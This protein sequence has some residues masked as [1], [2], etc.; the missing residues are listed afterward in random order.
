MEAEAR[1][2]LEREGAALADIRIERSMDIHYY[3]QVREQNADVPDGPV[4]AETLAVTVDRFHDKHRRVIG[5]SEPGYPTVIVRLHLAG[6]AK[7]V[8]PPPREIS[9]GSG[10]L[11]AALKGRRAAYFAEAGGLTEVPVYDGE[12]FGAGDVIGGPCI[13]EE[14]MTTLVLPPAEIVTVDSDGSYTTISSLA[15]DWMTWQTGR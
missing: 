9:R 11:A 7:I 13:I 1:R 5:Y 2:T 14:R 3:G 8:P 4:T 10:D 12:R 6:V 15:E